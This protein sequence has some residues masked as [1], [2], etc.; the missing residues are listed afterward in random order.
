MSEESDRGIRLDERQIR[1]LAHPLRARIPGLLRMGG[2]ATATDLARLL[3]TNSGATSYHLRQLAAVGLVTDTGEG[4]GRR[5]EWRATSD[6]HSWAPSDFDDRPDAAAAAGW[7]QR[8][9]L[10]DFVE[11]AERWEAAAP[12]WAPAWRD[13]LGLSDTVVEVTP[14]Q[15]T[16]MHAE[17]R[18]VLDRYHSAGAGSAD[19]IRLHVTTHAAPLEFSTG[20]RREDASPAAARPAAVRPEGDES[21]APA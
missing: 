9:Y 18:E 4:V 12:E 21:A 7:L 20:R 15:A 5:R 19:A 13:S 8:A 6:F 10:R 17:L 1:V 2:P 14:V 16:A 3:G 11:R